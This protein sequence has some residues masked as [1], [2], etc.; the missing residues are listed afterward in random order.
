MTSSLLVFLRFAVLLSLH[1]MFFTLVYLIFVAAY[2]IAFTLHSVHNFEFKVALY[3]CT[4]MKKVVLQLK[5]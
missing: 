5:P 2:L 3:T 4:Q 1:L